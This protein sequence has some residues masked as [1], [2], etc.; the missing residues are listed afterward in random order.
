MIW[1]FT[2]GREISVVDSMGR[3]IPYVKSFNDETGEIEV[4]VK[5]QLGNHFIVDDKSIVVFRATLKDAKIKD[6]VKEIF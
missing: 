2:N 5:P 3:I 1:D 4:F 6:K